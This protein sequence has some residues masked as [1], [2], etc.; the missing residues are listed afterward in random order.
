M[1]GWAQIR[2]LSRSEGLSE[3]EIARRLGL[4]RNTVSRALASDVPPVYS[5]VSGGSK[6]DPFVGRMREVLLVNP[7]MPATVVAE[8]VGYPHRGASIFRA[9]VAQIKAELGKTDPA[10]RL[11]FGPG[12]QFQCDLIIPGD[13]FT[14]L[15]EK[16]THPV[17]VI[18]DCFSRLLQAIMVPPRACG[19]LLSGM[20]V[21]LSRFG[22]LPKALLWDNE[23]GLVSRR[24]LIPQALAWSGSLGLPIKLAP[25]RDPETKGRVERHNQ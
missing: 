9:K 25:V 6:V 11:E 10:D 8:R 15:G 13:K 7:R 24:K 2:V 5:R 3:R 12:E 4:S 1:D 21:L 20:N 22:V 23:A 19:D 14:F 17:L 18:V 16:V